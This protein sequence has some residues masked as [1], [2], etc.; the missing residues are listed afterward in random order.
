MNSFI[1]IAVSYVCES[2]WFKLEMS[3]WIQY[4][5]AHMEIYY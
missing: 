1:E 4:V 3:G 2:E 5:G